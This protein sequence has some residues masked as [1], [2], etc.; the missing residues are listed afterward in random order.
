MNLKKYVFSL[1]ASG[2]SSFTEEDAL[3]QTGLTK[4]ALRSALRRLKKKQEIASPLKGFFIIVPPEYHSLRSLPPEQFIDDL[5]RYLN[6]SYYVGLLSAAQY[7]GAAHQKPQTFHVIVSKARKNIQVGRVTI[8]FTIKSGADH[9]LTRQFNTPRGF[10]RVA[11]PETTALD[12]VAFPQKSGG[13]AA[14]FE[15]LS[16]LSEHLSV[17]NCRKAI[18]QIKKAPLL[19]RLGYFFDLLELE[20]HARL[21]EEELK[22]HHYIRKTVLDPQEG[23]EGAML[24]ERW[25]LIIN[26]EL[27]LEHD[28]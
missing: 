2:K 7:Y 13:I 28:T 9:S 6:I 11:A 19:Q 23:F 17:E 27:E 26:T 20:E 15:I 3:K 18:S 16:D 12:V 4:I 25:N 21:C 1:V 8:T 22:K 14:A 5:M 10:V 24:N